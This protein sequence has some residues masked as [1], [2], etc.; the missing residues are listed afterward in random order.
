MSPVLAEDRLLA[1]GASGKLVSQDAVFTPSG[2][3]GPLSV[4]LLEP[5]VGPAH[6]MAGIGF[7]VP[8]KLAWKPNVWDSPGVSTALK[9]PPGVAVTV[10]PVCVTFALNT[11][12]GMTVW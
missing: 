9:V 4:A 8:L 11:E 1:I 2:S 5:C 7:D 6:V 12:L 3:S 10:D